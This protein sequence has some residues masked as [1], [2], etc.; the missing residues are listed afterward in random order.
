[1]NNTLLMNGFNVGRFMLHFKLTIGSVFAL[2]IF[3]THVSYAEEIRY[4][5]IE[6][7]ID[8]YITHINTLEN[9]FYLSDSNVN[10]KECVKKELQQMVEADQY[11]RNFYVETPYLHGYSE[12]EK[13]LFYEKAIVLMLSLDSKHTSEVKR[14]LKTYRWF[15]ISSFDA[16]TDRN[17][18]LLVQHAD[19]EPD[20]QKDVLK[21]LETFYP[22]YETDPKN[23]AYL[24]DRVAISA[25]N[26]SLRVLQKY[27][28]QGECKRPGE[29]KP[30]PI[31]N[32]EQLDQRRF[33]VG[34]NPMT[35]YILSGNTVCH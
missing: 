6:N 24:F 8:N 21:I 32:P 27:G 22:D 9:E 35:E 34:L 10:D 18:W 14:L 1:M 31:E 29:W 12:D 13:K 16:E 17:A 26:P 11:M 3:V 20:F 23:Y 33:E 30:F 2:L 25:H 7:D 28:T 19:N 4:S 5:L 15:T